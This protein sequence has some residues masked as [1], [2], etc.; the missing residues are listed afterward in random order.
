MDKVADSVETTWLTKFLIP[1]FR[2]SSVL[3]ISV[4]ILRRVY[5]A[6]L[7]EPIELAHMPTI[8]LSGLGV[9]ETFVETVGLLFPP[10]ELFIWFR[11]AQR[12]SLKRS[13]VSDYLILSIV[14]VVAVGYLPP[15]AGQ[16]VLHFGR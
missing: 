16:G 6:G 4:I 1:F 14:Y 3:C 13:T 9:S 8:L 7:L 2:V 12:G 10:V 11:L 15:P 5:L